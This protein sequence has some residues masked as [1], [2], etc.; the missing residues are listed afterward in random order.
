MEHLNFNPVKFVR[1]LHRILKPGGRACITVPNRASFQALFSL[2]TGR[3]QKAAVNS[4]FKFENYESNGKK[5]FYGFHW[6]EYTPGEL[7][8][9]FTSAGFKVR[10]GS[11]TA[12]QDHG[13]LGLGRRLAR[14]LS[15]SGMAILPRF[16]TNVYL[17]GVR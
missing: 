10:C 6:R 2:V 16:G 15:L 8:T 14:S 7:E 9:L 1:E 3:G 5:A 12:F 13:R 11:F 17:T 4:Y